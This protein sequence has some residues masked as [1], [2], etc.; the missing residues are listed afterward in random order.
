MYSVGQFDH[1]AVGFSVIQ[2]V[3]SVIGGIGARQCNPLGK[4]LVDYD[5]VASRSW[6]VR[7]PGRANDCPV[8]AAPLTSLSMRTRSVYVFLRMRQ[9]NS[10]A[11]RRCHHGPGS[12][13]LAEM[14]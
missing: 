8:H 9:R 12:R 10:L 2:V 5:L 3:D 6:P 7:K 13:P 4:M 11:N 14:Q 1:S